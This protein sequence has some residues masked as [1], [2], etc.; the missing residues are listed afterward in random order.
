[1]RK[2]RRPLGLFAA[3]LL[4][5]CGVS[6]VAQETTATITGQVTDSIGAVVSGAEIML[7]TSRLERREPPNRATMATIRSL[8]YT[9][10][11]RPVGQGAGLQRVQEQELELF[12]ND[13]KTINR[14]RNGRG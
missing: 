14:A 1:M 6:V 11:L 13:Q 5:V 3:L 9:R 10:P 8:S 2:T 4:L 7:T 12:V